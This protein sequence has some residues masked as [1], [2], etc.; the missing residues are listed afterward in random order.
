MSL[1]PTDENKRLPG[2][3]PL[4][5]IPV[6]AFNPLLRSLLAW[7]LVERR[8][9]PEGV[10]WALIEEA[11]RRLDSLVPPERRSATSLAYLDHWCARCRQQKLTHLIEGRFLCEECE[12]AESGGVSSPSPEPKNAPRR[13]RRGA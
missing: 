4:S 7:G 1:E 10:S 3:R 9:T 2:A 13:H 11:Q 8:Q 12:R 6:D 5:G